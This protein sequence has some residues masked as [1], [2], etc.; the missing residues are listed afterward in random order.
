VEGVAVDW[1]TAVGYQKEA[2]HTGALRHLLEGPRAASVARAL[3]GDETI[4]AVAGPRT[5]VK[6]GGASRR[7][8]DLAAELR[9]PDEA[10]GRLAVEVK[11]DSAWSPRQLVETVPTDCHGV[12]LALGLTAL[13]VDVRDIAA[14]TDYRY[15]WQLVGP[16]RFAD[17]V[18]EHA[19]GDPELAAYAEHL[20]R[21]AD[22]HREASDAVRE[23]RVVER[24]RKKQLLGHWA[25][26]GEVLRHRKDTAEWD[27][28][29]LI[30]GPL[31]TRWTPKHADGSGDYLEFMAEAATRS[32]CVKTY[33]PPGLLAAS[34]ARVRDRLD[35]L[36]W[37]DSRE[38][39]VAAKTCTAARFPLAGVSCAQAA[40]LVET[41]L[42][43]LTD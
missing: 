28:K 6:L 40:D 41:V 18:R 24:G 1:V 3:T 16:D 20:A 39:R 30:S 10:A 26:F 29:T 17:I 33:A 31:V 11:V 32:L 36:A 34:R 12:L 5:E 2:L 13:A 38:P 8:V 21:E 15:P 35:G 19:D 37:H 25:Y 42:E 43:R 9:L 7:P 4:T 22:T 27:R 23:G 14:L